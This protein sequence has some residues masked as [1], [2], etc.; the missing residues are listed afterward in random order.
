MPEVQKPVLEQTP[1]EKMMPEIALTQ[2]MSAVV[3]AEDLDY[4]NQ[5]K[6]HLQRVEKL[7]YAVR[8]NA[9]EGEPRGIL[10]HRQI[11]GDPKGRQVDHKD[12]DGLN[13]RRSNL[14]FC[15]HQQNHF[16]L[17]NQ[18]NTSS[19]YKG[20]HW[21]KNKRKWR[22]GLRMNGKFKHIGYFEGETQAALAYNRVALDYFGEFARLNE[23][24][25]A[26]QRA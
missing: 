19:V 10:M 3:D 7:S 18:I 16:N 22:A 4:L 1:E 20:V 26:Y 11:L 25:S 17:R 9:V 6:W 15:T 5:W 8:A 24:C 2:G 13:N 23:V 21:S 12:G 14:R